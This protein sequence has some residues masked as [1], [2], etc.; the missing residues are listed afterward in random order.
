MKTRSSAISGTGFGSV[1]LCLAAS[2]PAMAQV[3]PWSAELRPAAREPRAGLGLQPRTE[4]PVGCG[5][6][7]LPCATDRAAFAAQQPSALRWSLELSNVDLGPTRS[8]LGMAPARHGLNLSLVG[9]KPVFGSSFAVYGRLGG[10][11]ASPEAQG[12]TAFEEARTVPRPVP[13]WRALPQPR[14]HRSP[15]HRYD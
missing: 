8:A 10:T 12:A 3:D 14:T 1:V 11:Y 2:G 5:A 15:G 13:P 9:R 6:S 7:L 4:V